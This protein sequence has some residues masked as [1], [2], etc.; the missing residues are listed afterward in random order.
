MKALKFAIFLILCSFYSFSQTPNDCINA[1][2]ICGNGTF[3]SN[4]S[5]IGAVQEVEGCGG[6]EHNSDLRRA[7]FD[8]PSPPIDSPIAQ[9]IKAPSIDS[10]RRTEGIMVD[11]AYGR[12]Q[13]IRPVFDGD[14]VFD[15]DFV[16]WISSIGKT[17]GQ[18]VCRV[19]GR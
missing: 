18:S 11:Q 13:A 8:R 3:T 2:T 17:A 14:T 7:C 6:L 15:G 16:E 5:G 10:C 9:P 4:A 1:I 12:V 19:G